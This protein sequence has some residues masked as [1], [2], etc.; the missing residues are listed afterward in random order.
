[1]TSRHELEMKR[2]EMLAAVRPV[3]FRSMAGPPCKRCGHP[4]D[5]LTIDDS[6]LYICDACSWGC[7]RGEYGEVR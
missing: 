7:E 6:E 4:L 5:E 2:R 3:A 1:M